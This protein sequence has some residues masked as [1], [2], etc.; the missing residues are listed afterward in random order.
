VRG[1]AERDEI[2]ASRL[3][4]EIQH[5]TMET[6]GD[7]D[8]D[9]FVPVEIDSR[10]LVLA[11]QLRRVGQ[12]AFRS[13]LLG[14]YGRRCA[15]TGEHTEVVLDAAH[16]QPY[17]GPSSNHVQN[18]MLLTKEFHALF[19]SGYVTVT[20]DY[21][22][23]VSARLRED[24]KNGHLYYPFDRWELL[25]PPE[26]SSRPSPGALEWNGER[27]FLDQGAPRFPSDE[28]REG[29]EQLRRLKNG[30]RAGRCRSRSW[31]SS[32]FS[33]TLRRIFAVHPPCP[34]QQQESVSICL[35]VNG[36]RALRASCRRHPRSVKSAAHP[37]ETSISVIPQSP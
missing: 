14:T 20:P 1:K 15:I 10:E 31:A 7:L 23:G 21:E 11:S 32:I 29:S 3:L 17:L 26:E 9:S 27:V 12:G 33:A 37:H 8:S 24:W 6:P 28:G 36:L 35:S 5:D 2:R 25:V 34:V 18:G 22:V 13:R 4:A 19:D 30:L 16:I